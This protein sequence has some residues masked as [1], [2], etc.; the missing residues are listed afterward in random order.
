MQGAT[1][2][3]HGTDSNGLHVTISIITQT[4]WKKKMKEFK[5]LIFTLTIVY[6]Y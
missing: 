4:L 6:N 1:F 3:F 2:D 5:Q